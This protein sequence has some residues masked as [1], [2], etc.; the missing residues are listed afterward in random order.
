MPQPLQAEECYHENV[1]GPRLNRQWKAAEELFA[2]TVC[3]ATPVMR[4]VAFAEPPLHKCGACLYLARSAKAIHACL[5]PHSTRDWMQFNL[6]AHFRPA[7]TLAIRTKARDGLCQ[8]LELE[9]SHNGL[10]ER[11]IYAVAD[12]AIG[13]RVR[14]SSDRNL[15]KRNDVMANR[16]LKAAVR[17][18][19]ANIRGRTPRKSSC[20]FPASKGAIRQTEAGAHPACAR[21]ICTADREIA[22][23]RLIL[24]AALPTRTA[25]WLASSR[26][27]WW[28]SKAA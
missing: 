19:L 16:D 23:Q 1:A 22:F 28:A 13:Q 15:A 12:S 25:F 21:S 26:L 10:P 3:F 27:H 14:N 20:W 17:C 9:L 24:A 7:T 11:L 18:W 8:E 5:S 6:T 2:R 4:Q